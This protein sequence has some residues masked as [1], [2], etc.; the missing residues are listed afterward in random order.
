MKNI[1]IPN[2]IG[3]SLTI[4]VPGDHVVYI[5]KIWVSS[6]AT[7]GHASIRLTSHEMIIIEQAFMAN[8][9]AA[10]IIEL[11][12]MKITAANEF[13]VRVS[14]VD[15]GTNDFKFGIHYRIDKVYPE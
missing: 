5:D 14:N 4:E 1:S 12:G 6:G 2:G 7:T 11:Q 8:F 10:A 9:R 3:K 13:T 15:C